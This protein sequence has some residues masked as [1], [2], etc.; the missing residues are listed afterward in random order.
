MHQDRPTPPAQ[1]SPACPDCGAP[2]AREG[3]RL[4]CAAHGLFFRYGPRLLVRVAAP[5]P[6]A[7]SLLPW[8]TLELK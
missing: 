2:L 6:P 8:Q 3:E 7:Q 1:R 4:R 5:A